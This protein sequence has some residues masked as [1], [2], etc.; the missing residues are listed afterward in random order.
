MA[1]ILIHAREAGVAMAL[2]SLMPMLAEQGHT[3][4]YNVA[5]HAAAYLDGQPVGQPTDADLLLCGYDLPEIDAVGEVIREAGEAGITSISVLDAWKGLDRFWYRDGTLRLLT[6]KIAV[7]DSISA[8]WL[9]NEGIPT[10]HLVVTGHPGLEKTA[11]LSDSEKKKLRFAARK[12]I[13]IQG[14]EPILL[15]VSEVIFLDGQQPLSLTELFVDQLERQNITE[16]LNEQYGHEFH[17]VIRRHPLEVASLPGGWREFPE[18]DEFEML[19]AA[20]VVTGLCTTLLAHAV[21]LG[22]KVINLTSVI[23]GWNPENS[24]IPSGIWQPLLASGILGDPP[25]CWNQSS[26]ARTT[27]LG[28]AQS[29]CTLI[30]DLTAPGLRR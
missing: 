21:M 19:A 8:N 28:A 6:S 15:L 29:I 12:K 23:H 24:Y 14:Q 11:F 2:Q 4:L 17:L 3:F 13:G 1:R 18:Q 10:D 20:D 26:L 5:G 16:W 7:M 9:Q 30:A 25:G 27:H 22:R